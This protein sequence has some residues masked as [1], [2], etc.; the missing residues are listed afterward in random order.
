MSDDRKDQRV[1]VP[2]L[3]AKYKSATVDEFI[4]QYAGDISRGGIFIKTPKPS[5]IG[6][7]LKIEIQLKD[8]APVISAVGRV[9][10]RREQPEGGQAAGMGIKFIKLEPESVPVIERIVERKAP[11]EGPH[12]DDPNETAALAAGETNSEFFGRTNPQA[13][14]PAE[15]DRTMMRQMS[16]FL[17]EALR[18]AKEEPKPEAPKKPVPK[19]TMIGMPAL[20]PAQFNKAAEAVKSAEGSKAEAA[21]PAAEPAKPAVEAKA[22]EP[23]APEAKKEEPK[24]PEPTKKPMPKG[25]LVGMA[26]VVPPTEPKKEE[27]KAPEPTAA[28]AID[29]P[30]I[31][32][33][34]DESIA[35]AT[36]VTTK[37]ALD[38]AL[39]A[40]SAA[41]ELEGEPTHV[42][43]KGELDRLLEKSASEAESKKAESK[44]EAKAEEPEPKKEE[45]TPEPKKEEPKAEA[46]KP[47][48][49]PPTTASAMAAAAAA[50]SAAKK[51]EPTPE[52]KK[53]EPKK[54]EPKK[55][56]P[57]ASAPR[58]EEPEAKK[59]PMGLIAGVLVAA[60]IGAAAFWYVNNNQTPNANNTNTPPSV[61]D[62]GVAEPSHAEEDAAPANNAAPTPSAED[63][64]AAPA[65]A[66]DAAAAAEPEEQDSGAAAPAQNTATPAQT[67]TPEP[68]PTPTPTP[69]P[70]AD[71]GARP[72]P[73]P[74]PAATDTGTGA[75][76]SSGSS[77]SA[78]G[79]ESSGS[80]GSG[81]SGS[82]GSSG[83]S[84]SGGSVPENPI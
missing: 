72:R 49:A 42:A 70:A 80:G 28:T 29:A 22:E 25:T 26:V 74:T 36:A 14:M 60:G 81:G 40:A 56:E 67:A 9:V 79:S 20:S 65:Q 82:S 54:P 69:R 24:A 71:A 31:P 19:S 1:K 68:R 3:K 46:K 4:D 7:L 16:A 53:E 39:A 43:D 51:D 73:R 35:A 44:S 75:T 13:E 47:A 21:K 52:P 30:A 83:S 18:G 45:P 12:F 66:E 37:D 77:G 10:W 55:E 61:V 8:G 41:D 63:S 78:G 50:A 27:P 34:E 62:S 23:K 11:G 15:Q 57:V 32:G 76:G 58:K 64:G 2:T 38:K 6:Q 59:S 5:N 33:F 48:E 84:S 17:G